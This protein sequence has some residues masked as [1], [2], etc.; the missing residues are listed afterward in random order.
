MRIVF[1]TVGS[2]KK[3]PFL[4]ELLDYQKR[5]NRY[6]KS[7]IIEVKEV[8]VTSKSEV[9]AA[10]IK[11]GEQILKSLKDSDFVVAMDER[12]D[13]LTSVDFSKIIEKQK[14]IG[15]IKRIVFIIGASYGLSEF[16]TERASKVMALSKMIMTH[17]M[18]LLFL[19]EQVYRCF[20]I[21][22]NEP[23]SH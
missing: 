11:E 5:I 10:K 14:D 7:E 22:N 4:S 1:L 23:Y 9:K 20:T 8:K 18:A 2:I 12:G 13:N 6:L 3:S 15:Q 19:S 16:V 21:L 17:D